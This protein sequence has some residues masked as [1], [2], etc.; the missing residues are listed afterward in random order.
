MP[1]PHQPPETAPPSWQ[2]LDVAGLVELLAEAIVEQA[3]ERSLRS[4]RPLALSANQ[5]VHVRG[6]GP[7]RN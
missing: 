5:S 6:H 2:T 1:N 4:P 7:E 3:I